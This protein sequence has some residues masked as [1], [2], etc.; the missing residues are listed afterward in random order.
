MSNV[1]QLLV[2][3]APYIPTWKASDSVRRMMTLP[4]ASLENWMRDH[5]HTA[6]IDIG[7]SGVL[8]HSLARVRQLVGIEPG[9]L[10]EIAFR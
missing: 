2:L 3:E 7:S 9:E 1:G 4:E 6:V 10:D 8:D 5:C